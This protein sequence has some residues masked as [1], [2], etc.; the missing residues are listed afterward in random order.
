MSRLTLLAALCCFG[1]LVG[2]ALGQPRLPHSLER[3]G[4]DQRLGEQVP[5]DLSLVDEAGRQVKL[6]EFFREKPV[7]LVLAYYRCPMLCTLVLNGL[8]Q[9]L[10]DVDFDAGS[11]FQVVVVSFDVRETPTLA[12][13]KKQSYVSRYGRPG[14]MSGW[15]FLTGPSESIQ[16]LTEA[17]GFRYSYDAATD[18]FAHASG[19]MML[20]PGGKLA[21]Y[22]YDVRYSGRD[23]RLGL[24]EAGAGTIGSPV[25]QILL[26]C[27]HYDPTEGKYGPAVMRFVRIG[28]VLTVLGICTFVGFLRRRERA[29]P[30]G[31]LSRVV[32]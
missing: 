8:V 1:P 22:F 23:L 27:F 31:A 3:V 16:R 12:A 25:D 21:R 17:V 26:F 19:I 6:G 29:V 30:R 4:F 32:P 13:A 28:G 24:V 2:V 20:T 5:L 18:Q 7:I 10:L 9:G 11:D 15:H 14:A